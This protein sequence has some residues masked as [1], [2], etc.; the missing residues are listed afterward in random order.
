MQF[1]R[2]RQDYEGFLWTEG[3]NVIAGSVSML[4]HPYSFIA[5]PRRDVARAGHDR[6]RSVLWR[7]PDKARRR[8][9][10]LEAGSDRYELDGQATSEAD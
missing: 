4:D 8:V 9:V 1:P 3:K 7:S 2:A 6:P 5:D 10:R